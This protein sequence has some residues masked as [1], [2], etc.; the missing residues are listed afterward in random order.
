MKT[1]I[2]EQLSVVVNKN[3]KE[4]LIKLV[5]EINNRSPSKGTTVSRM[6]REIISNYLK[7][8]NRLRKNRLDKRRKVMSK[9]I[10][11]VEFFKILY[12]HCPKGK[13]EFYYPGW[14]EHRIF[15]VE[16]INE[17]SLFL[18][19]NTEVTFGVTTYDAKWK[20]GEKIVEIPSVWLEIELN[21]TLKEE[22]KQKMANFKLKPTLVV[23][24]KNI[25][26][27]YWVLNV[28]LKLGEIEKFKDVL[29]KFA[30]YFGGTMDL[31]ISDRFMR[32]PDKLSQALKAEELKYYD[33]AEL[34]A[35]IPDSE[36]VKAKL[37][38]GIIDFDP[39][40]PEGDPEIPNPLVESIASIE[41][42]LGWS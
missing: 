11:P 21:K 23:V 33:L 41:E 29:S 18:P 6:V 39:L 35:A 26:Q 27:Y 42:D 31:S 19:R 20:K 30:T 3:D 8:T 5:E 36:P 10:Q 1:L 22:R 13:V 12:K 14:D 38:K 25:Q 16:N 4:R 15:L 32:A 17:K 7:T 28:P 34:E 2:K 9:K 40:N 37:E 24:S